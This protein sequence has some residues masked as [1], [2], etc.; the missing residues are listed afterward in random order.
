MEKIT[1]YSFGYKEGR[2][3]N[4]QLV[5]DLRNLLPNPHKVPDLRG[6]DGRDQ[7]IQEWCVS[8]GAMRIAEKAFYMVAECG[9]HSVAF[10]CVGG[11]HRSV[12][13]ADMLGNMLRSIRADKGAVEVLHTALDSV[14]CRYCKRDK[15]SHRANDLA[16]PIGPKTRIG[17]ITYSKAATYQIGAPHEVSG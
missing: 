8:N 9:V 2:V 1:V 10:G 14:P 12:A 13:L 7:K 3:P 17:Y 15:G 11:K 4:A 6:L 5:I 16:C